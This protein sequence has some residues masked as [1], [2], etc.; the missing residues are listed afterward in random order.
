MEVLPSIDSLGLNEQ[1]LGSAYISLGGTEF[2]RDMFKE[3]T[4]RTAIQA[5]KFI[6]DATYEHQTPESPHQ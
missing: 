6:L 3:P 4:V 5:L 1:E 2:T